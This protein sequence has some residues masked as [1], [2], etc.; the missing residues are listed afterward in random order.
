MCY[1]VLQEKGCQP[2]PFSTVK[3]IYTGLWSIYSKN[4]EMRWWET[5]A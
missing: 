5:E 3:T 4:P 1:G 2:G